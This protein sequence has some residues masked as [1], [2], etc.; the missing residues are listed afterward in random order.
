MCECLCSPEFSPVQETTLYTTLEGSAADHTSTR[1]AHFSEWYWGHWSSPWILRCVTFL[2]L[3]VVWRPPLLLPDQ[4]VC[5]GNTAKCYIPLPSATAFTVL[6]KYAGIC[7]QFL[8]VVNVLSVLHLHFLEGFLLQ[9]R[10]FTEPPKRSA[11]LRIKCELCYLDDDFMNF[12]RTEKA[13][14][15]C[16]FFDQVAYKNKSKLNFSYFNWWNKTGVVKIKSFHISMQKNYWLD[17]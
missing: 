1:A 12:V 17:K 14:E 9:T 6:Q 5:S 11:V 16:F 2:F 4:A 13:A 10:C 7:C 8:K 3:S 15:K